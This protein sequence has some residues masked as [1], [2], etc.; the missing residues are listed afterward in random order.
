MWHSNHM[1]SLPDL[2]V[3][4]A[5]I[6]MFKPEMTASKLEII[7]STTTKTASVS[8]LNRY[9][10]KQDRYTHGEDR[11][12]GNKDRYDREKDRYNRLGL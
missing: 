2:I 6:I 7:I 3:C 1:V 5:K 4:E 10:G 12:G 9:D 11:Y 8:G